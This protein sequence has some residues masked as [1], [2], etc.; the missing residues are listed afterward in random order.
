M[1]ESAKEKVV[2]VID[3][4]DVREIETTVMNPQLGIAALHMAIAGINHLDP[5]STAGKALDFISLKM[6]GDIK[7]LS[8][9]FEETVFFKPKAA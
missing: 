8:E 1:K 2:G 5:N 3:V 7:A 6:D 9:W 4:A